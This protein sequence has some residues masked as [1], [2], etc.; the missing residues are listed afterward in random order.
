MITVFTTAPAIR[1]CDHEREVIIETD[2]SDYL[3]AGVLSQ[4]DNEGVLHP[5]ANFSRNHPPMGWNCDI[6]DTELMAVMKA[7][8]EWSPECEGA[9]YPLQLITDQNNLE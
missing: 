3:S 1:H 4:R 6:Y 2:A 7:L 9:T 5:V 8:E